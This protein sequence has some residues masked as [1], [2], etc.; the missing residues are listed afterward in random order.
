M[1]VIIQVGSQKLCKDN[2]NFTVTIDD[3][4]YHSNAYQDYTVTYRNTK[5]YTGFGM[6]VKI[7]GNNRDKRDKR[8]CGGFEL[9]LLDMHSIINEFVVV[10]PWYLSLVSQAEWGVVIL[11]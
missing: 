4:M 6:L 1:T 9:Q 7:E 11:D 2:H 8:V 5:S 3:K 10:S